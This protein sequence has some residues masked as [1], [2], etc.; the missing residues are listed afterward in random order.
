MICKSYGNIKPITPVMASSLT[1][2]VCPVKR[3][4]GLSKESLSTGGAV[5]WV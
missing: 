2:L 3:V 1:E 4:K 5:L